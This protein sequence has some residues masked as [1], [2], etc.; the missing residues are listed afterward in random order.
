MSAIAE[1]SY[2]NRVGYQAAILGGF[3]MVAAAFLVVGNIATRDAIEQRR[4]EDLL[5]SLSQVIPARIHD[6]DL[7]AHPLAIPQGSGKTVTVYRALR[8]HTVTGVAYRI[9]GQGYGGEIQ[10]IL[11][12]NARG[13]VLG[14]RVLAHAETPGLGDKIEAERDDWI[15]GFEGRSLGSPPIERWAVRKDG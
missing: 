5:A 10:L 12:L 9:T 2:R 15:L 1:P 11:G 14:A 7:L 3:T 8:G 4:T 13:E 6:N